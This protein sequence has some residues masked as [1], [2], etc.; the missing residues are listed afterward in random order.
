MLGRHAEGL[1]L[2]FLVMLPPAQLHHPVDAAP[3]QPRAHAGG[4]EPQHLV[5]ETAVERV[6]G[7]AVQMIIVIVGH[8]HGVDRR[9]L[10]NLQRR[11][12]GAFGAGERQ[13]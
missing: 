3:A 1:H 9:Q 7:G 13:R 5:A 2:A 10:V 12:D 8:Q 6:H 4:R 11:G